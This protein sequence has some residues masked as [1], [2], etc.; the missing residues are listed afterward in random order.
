MIHVRALAHVHM[1]PCLFVC[2]YL[3]QPSMRSPA[4]ATRSWRHSLTWS[5]PLWGTTL[6]AIVHGPHAPRLRLPPHC[7]VPRNVGPILAVCLWIRPGTR[8][9]SHCPFVVAPAAVRTQTPSTAAPMWPARAKSRRRSGSMDAP[10]S[11]P[12]IR[13]GGRGGAHVS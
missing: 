11:P 2:L 6:F 3:H 9:G 8:G 1:H 4:G 7:P 10:C 12:C 13:Y 5:G